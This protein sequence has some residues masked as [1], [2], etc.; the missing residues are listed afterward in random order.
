MLLPSLKLIRGNMLIT[1][2]EEL[3]VWNVSR[4][5]VKEIYFI[6]SEGSFSKDYQLKDQIRRAA[7]SI[8]LNISEGFDSRSSKTFV[9][10]LN[11]SYRSASETKSAL[12]ISL[13]LEYIN[14]NQFNN[15]SSKLLDI[16][17]MINRLTKYLHKKI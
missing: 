6:T 16:Q 12:Y 8:M 4:K 7:T 2:F 5:L 3:D 17:K 14:Q 9:N 1:K 15:L 13:D 10:F 11:Y